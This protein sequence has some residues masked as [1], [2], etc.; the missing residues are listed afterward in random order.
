M[1]S[2]PLHSLYFSHLTLNTGILSRIDNA[3]LSD[4]NMKWSFI[5]STTK[6]DSK[7]KLEFRGGAEG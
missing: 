2:F 7:M 5:G 3:N 4:N 1:G 6:S